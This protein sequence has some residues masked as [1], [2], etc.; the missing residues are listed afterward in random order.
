MEKE[1]KKSKYMKIKVKTETGDTVKV[2]DADDDNATEM[3]PEEV[4]QMYQNPDGPKYVGTILY[5]HSSPGCVVY[6]SGGKCYRICY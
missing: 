2:V 3:T 5:T 1:K 4:E 6:C